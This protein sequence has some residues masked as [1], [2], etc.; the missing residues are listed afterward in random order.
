MHQKLAKI[1]ITLPELLR[2]IL[3]FSLIFFI[4]VLIIRFIGS[5]FPSIPKLVNITPD[6]KK[7]DRNY[8]ENNRP[9][10]ILSNI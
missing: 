6:F 2:K 3:I 7:G 5:E 10:N 8:K 9:V 1:Q 4:A